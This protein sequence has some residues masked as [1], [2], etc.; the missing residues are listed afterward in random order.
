M[1]KSKKDRKVLEINIEFNLT[2]I[3]KWL[4]E[5][6]EIKDIEITSKSWEDCF[7]R[8]YN[9]DVLPNGENSD[10]YFHREKNIISNNI[11]GI[12]YLEG[13]ESGLVRMEKNLKYASK[14]SYDEISRDDAINFLK[15]K[16]EIH[17]ISWRRWREFI[18]FEINQKPIILVPINEFGILM[19]EGKLK[20]TREFGK[21][22]KDGEILID[23]PVLFSEN[24]QPTEHIQVLRSSQTG[25]S[26]SYKNA[27][28]CVSASTLSFEVEY[29]K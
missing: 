3:N 7:V 9:I 14:F 10:M 23:V 19:L 22:R 1:F 16:N 2:A 11:G 26:I 27:L 4:S 20:N 18:S 25:E 24:D 15:N 13:S 6:G 28:C 17:T 5:N 21:E 12:D 8:F 29:N